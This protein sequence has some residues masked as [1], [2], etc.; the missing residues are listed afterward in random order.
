ME[1]LVRIWD[2]LQE[3]VMELA[4]PDDATSAEVRQW[5][6]ENLEHGEKFTHSYRLEDANGNEIV[7]PLRLVS[8]TK[9]PDYIPE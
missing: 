7:F 3:L 1:E 8:D 9:F 5:R 4:M 6:V 2:T